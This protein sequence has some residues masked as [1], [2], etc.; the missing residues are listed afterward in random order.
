MHFSEKADAI[1]SQ[2]SFI[3][4]INSKFQ[5]TSTPS[6]TLFVECAHLSLVF[7]ISLLYMFYVQEGQNDTRRSLQIVD[8]E[9]NGHHFWE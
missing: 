8:K 7:K 2:G 6:F 4:S 5:Q 3:H 1:I 9:L